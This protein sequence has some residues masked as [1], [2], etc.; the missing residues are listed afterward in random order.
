MAI[1]HNSNLTKELTNGAKIQ[2]SFDKVPNEI[3]EKVVPV[4]EVNPKL[5]FNCNKIKQVTSSVTGTTL[6]YTTPS[7]KDFYLLGGMFS[8]NTDAANDSNGANIT[9]VPEGGPTT[10]FLGFYKVVSI[11]FDEIITISLNNPIKLGRNT[12]INIVDSFTAGNS[13]KQA[14]I[15]GYEVD[16]ANA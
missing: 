3:A 9:M 13:Y 4:M 16:N 8:M 11:A 12:T 1:I 2:T 6:I 5:L 15:Y 7:D 14:I 10:R